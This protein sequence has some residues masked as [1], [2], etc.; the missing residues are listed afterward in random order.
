MRCSQPSNV[1]GAYCGQRAEH[2]DER[3][4]GQVLGVGAVARQPV[5]QAVDAIG[6]L[7]HHL[8][9]RGRHP[10]RVLGGLTVMPFTFRLSVPRIPGASGTDNQTNLYAS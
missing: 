2:P 7:A 10:R 4:L 8:V 3:L 6:V 5:G 1:P 9:P